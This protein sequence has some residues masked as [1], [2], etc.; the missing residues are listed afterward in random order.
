M[1]YQ[2]KSHER[3]IGTYSWLNAKYTFSFANY[4]NPDF[5]GLGDL[6]V[7][8]E[9]RI[10]PGKGFDTHS[11]HDMEIITYVIDGAIK[12][13]DSMGRE[14]IVRP[15]EIQYMGAGS[16]VFHSEH[17]YLIDKETHLIQIWIRP[18]AMALDPNYG[19]DSY[20][21]RLKTN[22]LCLL[23]SGDGR[24]G[25]IK[26]N[27][28]ASL[29]TARLEPGKKIFYELDYGRHAWLQLIKGEL[30]VNGKELETGDGLGISDIDKFTITGK[31]KAEFLLFDLR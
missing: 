15:G 19:Q 26:I 27:Q 22:E 14:G 23:L 30:T 28:D 3:G 13:K 10:A 2:R 31:S 1:F 9:D 4:Y 8:N 6:L 17:N 12:H 7:I 16:G 24:K 25:S 5:M 18:N 11:H 21:E 20:M 29:Y